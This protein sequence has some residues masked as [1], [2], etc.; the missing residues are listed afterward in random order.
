M[1]CAVIHLLPLIPLL[2]LLKADK[3]AVADAIWKVFESRVPED[4]SDDDILYDLDVATFLQCI[5]WSHSYTLYIIIPSAHKIY[6]KKAQKCYNAF[7]GYENMS[8]KYMMHQRQS[9]RRKAGAA[10]L[11]C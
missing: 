5:P 7:D 8:V 6:Y 3:P 4:I 2:L 11:S 1:S 10:S 9:K